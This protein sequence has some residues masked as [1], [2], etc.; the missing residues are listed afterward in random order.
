MA[1]V[2]VPEADAESWLGRWGIKVD[3]E[4]HEVEEFPTC[5][6]DFRRM[7][8]SFYPGHEFVSVEIC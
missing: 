2:E 8:A 7:D 6:Q 1:E 3:E 4:S 5:D